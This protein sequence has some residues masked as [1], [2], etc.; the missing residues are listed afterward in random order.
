MTAMGETVTL[1]VAFKQGLD[2]EM[3]ANEDIVVIGTDMFLRGGHFAQARGLGE[4]YGPE[5]VRNA[6]IS[7]CAIVAAGVGAAMN[8]MRPVIDLNFADFALSAMD[9][10]VN[11]A[12]KIRYMWGRPVPLVVRV[13]CG[14]A[15]YA[16]QHNNSLESTFAHVPGLVVVQPS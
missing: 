12:A 2:E 9:E 16:A 11:Q 1:G 7:E 14:T 8:G 10:I 13:S 15:A 5:R 4:K 6:P 3:E